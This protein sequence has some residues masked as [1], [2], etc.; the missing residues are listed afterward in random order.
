MYESGID[1]AQYVS[2][3][4]IGLRSVLS[5]TLHCCMFLVVKT[6]IMNIVLRTPKTLLYVKNGMPS[7]RLTHISESY[8]NFYLATNEVIY[9]FRFLRH[10]LPVLT[11]GVPEI[12]YSKYMVFSRHLLINVFA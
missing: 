10:L 4:L 9:V 1:V 6:L 5:V 2:N 8:S 7:I 3:A 12:K 11:Q